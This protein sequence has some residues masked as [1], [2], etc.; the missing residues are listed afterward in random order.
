M[1]DGCPNV[2]DTT[3]IS[4]DTTNTRIRLVGRGSVVLL[5]VRLRPIADS[6][7]KNSCQV[8]LAFT[9]EVPAVDATATV[10]MSCVLVRGV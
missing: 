1:T 10:T 4:L 5:T 9:L 2:L 3:S 6:H 8:M 7:Q